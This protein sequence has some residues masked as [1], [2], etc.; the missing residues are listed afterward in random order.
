[1]GSPIEP[2]EILAGKYRVERVLGEGGMGVVLAVTHLGLKK[3][4]AIKL[5]RP[6]IAESASATRRFLREAQASA[7]LEGEKP[8]RVFDVDK[9]PTGE[10]Y[11]V[12]EHLIGKDLGRSPRRRPLPL[13][14]V[15]PHLGRACEAFGE[16]HA[17]AGSSTGTSSRRT[18]SSRGAPT[19]RPRSRCS[20]FGIAKAARPEAGTAM[21]ARAQFQPDIHVP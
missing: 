7:E 13:G 9:L 2:G 15:A 18:S 3:P 19:A 5:M 12:M 8:V 17:R 20:I 16:A 10:P 4:R 21:T 11:L 6:E 1:M 14:E